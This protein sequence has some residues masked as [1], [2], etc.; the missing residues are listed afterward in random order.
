MQQLEHLDRFAH[1]IGDDLDRHRVVQVA[2]G[3]GV[4]Q[5]QVVRGERGDGLDVVVGEPHP[6][7]DLA[8]VLGADERVVAWVALADVVQQ[9]ADEQQ[10]GTVDLAG[11][12]G[13]VRRGLEQVPVD[14]EAMHR[15]VLCPAAHRVPFRDQ[16]AQQPGEIER[17]EHRDGRSTGTEQRDESSRTSAGHGS[18]TGA[19]SA[20][21]RSRV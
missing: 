17:F 7:G 2:T 4:G 3:R 14:G 18:G 12:V 21:S 6:A 10:V 20:R 5:Q 1:G 13:G 8:S 16:R 19:L 9:R 11:V 15:V